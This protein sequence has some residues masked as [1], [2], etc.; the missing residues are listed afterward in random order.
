[1]AQAHGPADGSF[2]SHRV[3]DHPAVAPAIFTRANHGGL[4]YVS[5]PFFSVGE[6]GT[7]HRRLEIGWKIVG[8]T[9]SP[10]WGSAKSDGRHFA[11]LFESAQLKRHWFH[12]RLLEGEDPSAVT[13]LQRRLD[14]SSV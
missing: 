6:N 10:P 12:V 13:F 9:T 3:G 11:V 2:S 1:M 8:W 5:P 14:A 4:N 7:F